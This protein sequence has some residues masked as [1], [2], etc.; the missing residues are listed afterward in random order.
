MIVVPM[1]FLTHLLHLVPLRIG[2]YLPDLVAY[3]GPLNGQIGHEV[4]S[5]L[6]Q[7]FHLI[8]VTPAISPEFPQCLVICLHSFPD[9]RYL[10][11]RFLQNRL[12]RSTLFRREFETISHFVQKIRFALRS[13]H[14]GMRIV[15][16]R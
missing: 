10:G 4:A 14:F 3:L 13:L 6:R 11:F 9:A 5:L 15:V 16:A 7:R 12:D 1:L 8:T 2:Q